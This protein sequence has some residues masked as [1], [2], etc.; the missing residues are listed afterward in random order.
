MTLADV[1]IEVAHPGAPVSADRTAERLLSRVHPD[2]R[3]RGGVQGSPL[4]P[5]VHSQLLFRDEPLAAL[6]THVLPAVIAL[7][8][9]LTQIQSAPDREHSQVK[10]NQRKI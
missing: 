7:V 9:L 3:D 5:D 4:L 6:G 8:G 10:L 2:K 1:S